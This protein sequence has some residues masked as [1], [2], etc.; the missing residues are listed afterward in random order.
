MIHA[1][2]KVRIGPGP[3]AARKT[4]RERVHRER[5]HARDED[6]ADDRR[7]RRRARRGGRMPSGCRPKYATDPSPNPP[8]YPISVDASNAPLAPARRSP[9]AGRRRRDGAERDRDERGSAE[10]LEQARAAELRR[11]DAERDQQHGHDADDRARHQETAAAESV[12]DIG[13][14]SA[15]TP[16]RSPP[17][18]ADE[19]DVDPVRPAVGEVAEPEL[20]A[21]RRRPTAPTRSR[22][23]AISKRSDRIAEPCCASHHRRA[24]RARRRPPGR[25]RV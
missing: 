20:H 12:G 10:P 11:A 1:G 13:P 8:A 6:E 16:S 25:S 21:R 14:G 4:T 15:R 3:T 23:L 5:R 17:G 18:A 7:A 9:I 19:A 22:P 2:R 24:P